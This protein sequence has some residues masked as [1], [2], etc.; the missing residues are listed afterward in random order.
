MTL[1]T[2]LVIETEQ[3]PDIQ[4]KLSD[5]LS[6]SSS[7]FSAPSPTKSNSNT[8]LQWF[9]SGNIEQIRIA[10]SENPSLLR[11]FD[12][13]GRSGAH[14]ASID[15][16]LEAIKLFKEFGGDVNGVDRDGCTSLIYACTYNHVDIAQYLI[17][18]CQSDL[19][20]ANSMGLTALHYICLNNLTDLLVFINES[21]I[22]TSSPSGLSLLHC[23]CIKG[24]IDIFKHLI[25]MSAIDMTVSD[26]IEMTPLHYLCKYGY[27]S[28]VEIYPRNVML[29]NQRNSDGAT[30]L[31]LA[32]QGGYFDIVK[33]IAGT[34]SHDLIY[35][36][37]KD[38]S[39]AVHLA[40]ISGS[41]ELVWWLIE[42]G[43]RYDVK[44]ASGKYPHQLAR[45]GKY[46]K[47]AQNLEARIEGMY[48]V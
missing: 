18:E 26:S 32:C 20:Y 48:C 40:C 21:N 38:G 8:F 13:S 34:I 39:N 10:L 45:C 16:H 31:L 27:M 36:T 33:H 44:N 46:I 11:I 23:V 14:L 3:V 35:S 47:L 42:C 4:K 2:K 22:H 25:S 12:I 15:G 29:F 43:V 37:L 41:D 6:S 17:T 7:H 28:L 5:N 30:P 24:H 1:G 19:K 9:S